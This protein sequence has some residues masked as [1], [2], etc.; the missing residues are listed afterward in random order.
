LPHSRYVIK[1]I[2]SIWLEDTEVHLDVH[3]D[4]DGLAVLHCRNEAVF[5]YRFKRGL[6]E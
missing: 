3:L 4:W 2:E 1:I 6:T 5:R